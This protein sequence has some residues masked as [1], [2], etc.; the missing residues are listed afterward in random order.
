[1]RQSLHKLDNLE[2]IFKNSKS[3]EIQ[4]PQSTLEQLNTKCPSSIYYFCVQFY[5]N[6][7]NFTK[8]RANTDIFFEEVKIP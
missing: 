6:S 8:V 1:M 7:S 4:T 5:D 3:Q 2:Q